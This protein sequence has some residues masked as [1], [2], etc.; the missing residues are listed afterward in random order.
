MLHLT[1]FALL[2]TE[3]RAADHPGGSARVN[4]PERRAAK[5]GRR[6]GWGL[7]RDAG[8]VLIATL[9]RPA[10]FVPPDGAAFALVGL[11]GAAWPPSG[12]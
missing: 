7:L 9:L 2:A 10:A 5:S 3:S 4:A 8:G 11:K 12:R 6:Y 1:S